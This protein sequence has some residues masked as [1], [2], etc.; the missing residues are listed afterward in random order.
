[1]TRTY[2][3]QAFL[4]LPSA[5][6]SAPPDSGRPISTVIAETKESSVTNS[7][8]LC[9][10]NVSATRKPSADRPLDDL[11]EFSARM[12][13]VINDLPATSPHGSNV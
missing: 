11:K 10:S 13:T 6:L 1:M 5:G 7:C 2:T 3:G 12:A 9:P 4:P 8:R